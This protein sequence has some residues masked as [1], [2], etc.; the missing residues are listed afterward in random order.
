MIIR[1]V[2]IDSKTGGRRTY[3][4][5]MLTSLGCALNVVRGRQSGADQPAVKG[6]AIDEPSDR[7][8]SASRSVTI[9][10]VAPRCSA[11]RSAR[12]P[13]ATPPRPP[14]TTTMSDGPTESVSQPATEAHEPR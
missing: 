1:I 11:R 12:A 13:V 7:M 14:G 6:A 3:V 9:T 10:T 5:D 2:M 8:S 4:F